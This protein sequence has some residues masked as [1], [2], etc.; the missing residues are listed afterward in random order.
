MCRNTL[1]PRWERSCT[2]TYIPAGGLPAV[3]SGGSPVGGRCPPPPLLKL[4]E[5]PP[6][7]ASRAKHAPA[8]TPAPRTR[9][10]STVHLEVWDKERLGSDKLLGSCLYPFHPGSHA[11]RH[12]T[13]R[14]PARPAA[15]GAG[16]KTSSE[17]A[18]PVPGWMQATPATD[19]QGHLQFATPLAPGTVPPAPGAGAGTLHWALSF[20]PSQGAGYPGV[21]MPVRYAQNLSALAG[22][23][24]SLARV[25]LSRP[26]TQRQS[27][28]REGGAAWC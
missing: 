20:S 13:Q 7:P 1:N 9:A 2:L 28:G 8:A 10:G 26:W 19:S 25:L 24:P 23:R 21:S 18:P 6:I 12:G 22:E 16:G 4:L 5:W 17:A 3:G 27:T 11:H 15:A 14:P